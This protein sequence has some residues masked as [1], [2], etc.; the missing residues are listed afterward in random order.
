MANTVDGLLPVLYSEAQKVP[1]EMTGFIAG[2]YQNFDDKMAGLNQTIRVP[3]SPAQAV[4]DY[5][6]AQTVT[7]GSNRV[8]SYTDVTIS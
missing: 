7:V 4:S 2:A 8:F 1:R 3:V 6:P 5:T